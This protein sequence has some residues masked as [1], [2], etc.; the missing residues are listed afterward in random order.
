MSQA[1]AIVVLVDPNSNEVQTIN[2]TFAPEI[3]PVITVQLPWPC[4]EVQVH[5]GVKG[6]SPVEALSLADL[7]AKVKG[8]K[9]E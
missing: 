7:A 4:P 1:T 3:V 5:Y 9:G 8:E 2:L 6:N